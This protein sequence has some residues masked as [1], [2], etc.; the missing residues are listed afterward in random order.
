MVGTRLSEQFGSSPMSSFAVIE[1]GGHQYRVSEGDVLRV[2]YRAGVDEGEQLVL[3]RVLMLGGD[4]GTT[5][6]KPVVDGAS[7]QATVTASPVK[8]LKVYTLK[9]RFTNSSKTKSGHRQ[10]YTL[11]KIDRI[12]AG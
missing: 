11:L 4:S 10:K 8:G 12:Q 9:R 3:D 7:V 5:I 6:G 2:E 1:D